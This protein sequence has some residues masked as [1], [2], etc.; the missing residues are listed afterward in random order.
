MKRHLLLRSRLL[1]IVASLAVI[2]LLTGRSDWTVA[3][4]PTV[5]TVP[6]DGVTAEAGVVSSGAIIGDYRD[7]GY[8][9]ISR[10]DWA[11]PRRIQLQRTPV[12]FPRY[13]PQTFFGQPTPAH[14]DPVRHYPVIPSPTDTAQLGYYYLHVPSWQPNPGMLPPIPLP[15]RWH[16]RSFPPH[17]Y[18][19]IEIEVEDSPIDVEPIEG[20][21]PQE[22]PAD[23]QAISIQPQPR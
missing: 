20:T 22:A 19:G 13:W 5:E 9:H 23:Q 16:D 10:R 18:H 12:Y 11:P 15:S 6:V 4:E 21:Q 1:S 3:D 14:S 17:Q 8:A 2:V 7:T